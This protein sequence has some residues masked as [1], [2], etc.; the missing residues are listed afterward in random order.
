[1][2]IIYWKSLITGFSGHGKPMKREYA[3]WVISNV[4]IKNVIHWAED[5]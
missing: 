1:M 5:L 4:H 3:H 2:C